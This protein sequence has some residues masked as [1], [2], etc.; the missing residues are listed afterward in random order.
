MKKNEKKIRFVYDTLQ[1]LKCQI[2]LSIGFHCGIL[3][4]YGIY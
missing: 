1:T 2:L 4:L 3:G